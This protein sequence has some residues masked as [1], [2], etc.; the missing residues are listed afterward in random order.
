MKVMAWHPTDDK[1]LPEQMLIKIFVAISSYMA[2][3]GHSEW[4]DWYLREMALILHMF[5]SN[6]FYQ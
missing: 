4:I 2:S 6:T 3:L 1:P 5:S